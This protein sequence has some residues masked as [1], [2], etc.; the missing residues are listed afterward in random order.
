MRALIAVTR[1]VVPASW[2]VPPPADRADVDTALREQSHHHPIP[3]L[4][5]S[6]A[7]SVWTGV[8]FV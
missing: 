8:E 2:E 7:P 6:A 3:R 4:A 5:Q 1:R